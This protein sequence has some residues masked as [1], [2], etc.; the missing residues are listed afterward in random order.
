MAHGKRLAVDANIGSSEYGAPK[1]R[2]ALSHTANATSPATEIVE[3]VSPT[4]PHLAPDTDTTNIKTEP[5]DEGKSVHLYPTSPQP[6]V[7][8][9]TLMW[10]R[11]DLRLNDNRALFEASMRSKVAPDGFLVAIYLL[12]PEEW[13]SHDEA[14]VKIDFWMR[15][16]ATLRTDL[17]QLNIPLI[18]RTAPKAR[19]VVDIVR[20]IVREFDISHVFWNKELMVD[21]QR[22]DTR[23]KRALE[24]QDHI[25]VQE[26]DDQCIVPPRD[27]RTK[28]GNAYSVFTPYYK[29]WSHLVETE[30]HYLQLSAKPDPNRIQARTVF[31]QFFHHSTTSKTTAMGAMAVTASQTEPEPEPESP[32][33]TSYPHPLDRNRIETLFPAG[34][35]AAH[36]RLTTFLE[37]RVLNYHQRRD[38]PHDE[39]GCSSLSPYLAA[40]VLSTRQCVVAARA[41]ITHITA[42]SN[43]KEKSAFGREGIKTW[44]K[45][46]GWRLNNIGYMHNRLRMIVACFLVKDLMINWQWGEKYFMSHLI[47]GD[48]ASNNGGWQWSAST[49]TDAQ[50]YFR[51]FNPLLQSQRF[52]PNGTF[53][54]RWVPELRGLT[55]KQIHEPFKILAPSQ[56]AKLGYPKPIVDHA[57]VKTRYINEFKRVLGTK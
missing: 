41:T 47:D 55:D 7:T 11:N 27:V 45:E 12:S 4:S 14:P 56:F 9:N 54:R 22:R 20:A 32:I 49:G 29:T 38:V 28:T 33:P 21:E 18:V 39:D 16:L 48:L 17:D 43:N 36:A 8:K 15:N 6:I 37:H 19:D 51:I 52:D 26:L 24:E 25:I 44:I 42:H 34:E 1:K 13:A 50:P 3:A 57:T 40:G 10:F 31:H 30:P 53:I 46:I 23:V 5:D 2:L 35:T